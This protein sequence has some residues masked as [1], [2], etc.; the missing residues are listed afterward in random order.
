MKQ[1]IQKK[2]QDNKTQ[3][4]KKEDVPADKLPDFPADIPVYPGAKIISTDKGAIGPSA[5][6]QTTDKASLVGEFY[7]TE[8]KK[9]GYTPQEDNDK[10]MKDDRGIITF[11]KEGKEYT[12]TYRY[13]DD[14][15]KT[16]IDISTRT[17]KLM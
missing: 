1:I 4:V 3:D 6:L 10:M 9:N 15:G 11:R 2:T 7:K 5:T 12:I 16:T 17:L 14:K 8:M 13:L